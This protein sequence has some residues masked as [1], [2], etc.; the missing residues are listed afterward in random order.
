MGRGE[1]GRKVSGKEDIGVGQESKK[2]T[3]NP[4]HNKPGIL[5]YCQ[6]TVGWSLE[7][8]ITECPPC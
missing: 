7:G 4:F 3:E 8:M 1:R 5:G 6:V 2:R